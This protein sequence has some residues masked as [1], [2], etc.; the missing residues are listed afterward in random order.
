MAPHRTGGRN[1]T[2]VNA[3]AGS[4]SGTSGMGG[5]RA[6]LSIHHHL[7]L[8]REMLELFQPYVFAGAAAHRGGEDGDLSHIDDQLGGS[9]GVR[10]SVPPSECSE[11]VAD[12][13]RSSVG[14]MRHTG[15]HT[16]PSGGG[17][18]RK[19]SG[20]AAVSVSSAASFGGGEG[21]E[22]HGLDDATM[23]TS[24]RRATVRRKHSHYASSASASAHEGNRTLSGT[25]AA[26]A[27]LSP[28][29]A[30]SPLSS[31]SLPPLPFVVGSTAPATRRGDD[32]SSI[33]S[34][35]SSSAA[36]SP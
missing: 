19:L 5:D 12:G 4:T 21:A 16:H 36:S 32:N 11:L 10:T 13:D 20:L 2:G 15:G 9:A 1:V 18:A 6:Q 3:G 29:S 8:T 25:A 24:S 31:S 34:A 22:R 30:Q 28:R 7:P 23:Q 14:G 33:V 27:S 26:I 17:P 35:S